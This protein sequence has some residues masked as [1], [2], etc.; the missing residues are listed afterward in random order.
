MAAVGI[1]AARRRQPAL[2]SMARAGWIVHAVANG[3]KRTALPRGSEWGRGPRPGA[4]GRA[5]DFTQR[6]LTAA[7]SGVIILLDIKRR[8]GNAP[9]DSP[10]REPPAGARRQG[11]DGPANSPGTAPV[12]R[13]AQEMARRLSPLRK[14]RE[15]RFGEESGWYRE[16]H[17]FVLEMAG[18]YYFARHCG[19][20]MKRRKSI[21]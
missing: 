12:P 4:A 7:F 13:S 19:A 5:N 3:M 20:A 6:P 17:L 18:A 14:S 1:S 2:E 9:V 16:S 21:P 11:S 8:T 10:F 15:L